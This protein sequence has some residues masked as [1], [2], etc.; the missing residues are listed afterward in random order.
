MQFVLFLPFYPPNSPK[1]YNFR[2]IKKNYRDIIILH[3][4]TKIYD[5]M[6][7]YSS[8]DMVRDR[9][10][11]GWTDGKSDIYESPVYVTFSIRLS[12]C[13]SD[14]NF[15]QVFRWGTVSHLKTCQTSE[16]ELFEEI[17]NSL[18][19]LTI[20]V[21]IFTLEIGRVLCYLVIITRWANRNQAK[22]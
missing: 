7:M 9:R 18:Q 8:W 6:M 19:L 16:M 10:T 1:N 5:Q 22:S 21:K 17:L 3:R 15:L 2:K 20:L 4:S 12:V 14:Y 11:D 13:L